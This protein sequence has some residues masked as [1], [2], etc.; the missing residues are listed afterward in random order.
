MAELAKIRALCTGADPNDTLVA[1]AAAAVQC[2]QFQEALDKI[3]QLPDDAPQK[4]DFQAQNIYCVCLWQ[5]DQLEDAL[6]AFNTL[7]EDF[8]DKEEPVINRDKVLVQF[9][10][11]LF[12][13]AGKLRQ[14][15]KIK[16]SSDVYQEIDLDEPA[17]PELRFNVANNYGIVLMEQKDFAQ[18]LQCFELA[19]DVRPECVEAMHNLGLSCI[20]VNLYEKAYE[21]FSKAV[22]A[23]PDLSIALI[24]KIECLVAMARYDEVIEQC[25]IAIQQLPNDHRPLFMRGYSYAQQ[26][27]HE[28]ALPDL[29]AGME[30]FKGS[31]TDY[32]KFKR[33][34]FHI[35][36]KKGEA[37]L[38]EGRFGEA[39]PLFQKAIDADPKNAAVN[40]VK[41]NKALCQLNLDDGTNGLNDAAI[42]TLKEILK[43]D[44]TMKPAQI[45]FGQLHCL[46]EDYITADSAFTTALSIDLEPDDADVMY[47][48]GVVILRNENRQGALDRFRQVLTLEADHQMAIAAIRAL[49]R[50][51]VEMPEFKLKKIPYQ[52]APKPPAAAEPEPWVRPA[53]M[54]GL[55]KRGEFMMGY[56][57]LKETEEDDETKMFANGWHPSVVPLLLKMNKISQNDLEEAPLAASVAIGSTAG[58]AEKVPYED[59]ETFKESYVNLNVRK[60]QLKPQID[61]TIQE[62]YLTNDEFQAVFEMSPEEFEA[63]PAWKKMTLKKNKGLF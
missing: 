6:K 54:K 58:S 13:K 61:P 22:A 27:R 10:Y 12:Q 30:C 5:T 55:R 50:G 3:L 42:S 40:V 26:G 63:A 8:P 48:H 62:K 53:W 47:N 17:T 28:E 52:Y 24:G 7:I 32:K 9:K 21:N 19:L 38:E 29:E 4:L 34:I 44:R 31:P 60:D 18:A 41:F 14:E 43:A 56:N 57:A 20:R 33:W 39:L 1:E 25:G 16:E 37:A 11:R 36:A 15:R 46:L 51:D 59:P 23:R 49:E 2:K 45:A 35:A